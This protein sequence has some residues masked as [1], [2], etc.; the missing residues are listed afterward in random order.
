M[1]RSFFKRAKVRPYPVPI[2]VHNLFVYVGHTY[3]NRLTTQI[4]YRV[5]TRYEKYYKF[6][7]EFLTKCKLLGLPVRR[8]IGDLELRI[9]Q[10]NIYMLTKN[11][12]T[13]W[14]Y[15]GERAVK[16]DDVSLLNELRIRANSQCPRC[17]HF[18]SP[19]DV[20]CSHCGN[21][22]RTTLA[23]EIRDHIRRND[24]SS[25]FETWLVKALPIWSVVE[26]SHP[27]DQVRG[28][29]WPI[30]IWSGYKRWQHQFSLTDLLSFLQVSS[31]DWLYTATKDGHL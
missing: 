29:K 17:R 11:Y 18:F 23:K 15:S 30:E 21:A 22:L 13:H 16:L 28:S 10:S 19:S 8:K 20:F 31:L 25:L 3:I 27:L 2:I 9:Y 7:Q 6:D 5:L 24:L 14:Q 4:L 12:L 26:E 1:L